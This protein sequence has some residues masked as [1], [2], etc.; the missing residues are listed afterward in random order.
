MK[1]AKSSFTPIRVKEGF[2]VY[3]IILIIQLAN[4][5]SALQDSEGLL[6]FLWG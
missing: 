3:L 6:P 4:S 5:A 2:W 1:P